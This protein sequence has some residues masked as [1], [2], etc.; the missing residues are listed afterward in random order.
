MKSNL[1]IPMVIAGLLIVATLTAHLWGGCGFNR[2]LCKSWC[3]IRHL[4][5]DLRKV[6]CRARC[7]ADE[8][9]CLAR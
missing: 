3:E 5:S 8:V 2:E 9:A 1:T 7:A 4:G 6:A